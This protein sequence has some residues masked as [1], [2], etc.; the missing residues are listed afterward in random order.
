[1]LKH[2]EDGAAL[3]MLVDDNGVL[4]V[5]CSKCKRI[6][7]SVLAPAESPAASDGGLSALQRA[8]DRYPSMLKEFGIDMDNR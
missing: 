1:M 3:N 2:L 7:Q 6:W 5:I 8:R 4:L